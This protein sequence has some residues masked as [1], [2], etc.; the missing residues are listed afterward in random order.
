MF[1]WGWTL[2]G[3]VVCQ[4]QQRTPCRPSLWTI[5][6]K[7]ESSYPMTVP[8]MSSAGEWSY[9]TSALVLHLLRTGTRASI[10][11]R[12]SPSQPHKHCFLHQIR[13][14]PTSSDLQIEIIGLWSPW[15]I[16]VTCFC[17]SKPTATTKNGLRWKATETTP[18]KGPFWD[19]QTP[20]S[21]VKPNLHEK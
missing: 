4:K 2:R 3:Y 7:T 14:T 13:H 20:S 21:S 1:P 5:R 16:P 19:P 15:Q 18:R 11:V 9:T 8:H 12:G 17:N 6:T 10:H